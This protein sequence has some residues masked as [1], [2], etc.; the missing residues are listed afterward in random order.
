MR[1]RL[2]PVF[3]RDRR[4]EQE[5]Q[6][7]TGLWRQH[8]ER[9]SR[10]V[11]RFYERA[12]ALHE[13][14]GDAEA[15]PQISELAQLTLVLND[16]D[17]RV[18]A[19][20]RTAQGAVPLEGLVFPAAGRARLGDVPE[21]L[22]RASALVAHALQ[23]ATMLHARLAMDPHAPSAGAAEF[24]EAARTY[25]DRAAGLIDEAEAGLPD[26]LRR[27]PPRGDPER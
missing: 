27:Q 3:R 21:H 10:A 19:L 17:D 15:A 13:E 1:I 26:D 14:H 20:A 16:L 11:D 9:F 23:S 7:G 2:P 5:K 12:S 4:S 8:R 22:S 18:A 25:V 24:A 6:F